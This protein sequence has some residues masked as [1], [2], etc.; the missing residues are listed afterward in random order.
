MMRDQKK[1]WFFGQRSTCHSY[2]QSVSTVLKA[3]ERGL[4]ISSWSC[5]STRCIYNAL[6]WIISE[7]IPYFSMAKTENLLS[8]PNLKKT[9]RHLSCFQTEH[10]Q[11]RPKFVQK[12]LQKPH[13]LTMLAACLGLPHLD[14]LS[15]DW[16]GHQEP[17]T[18]H[19]DKLTVEWDLLRD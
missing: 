15:Q 7:H 3:K 13:L 10:L 16:Q 17:H 2:L 1:K 8:E 9:P 12:L 14:L 6:W 19:E 4:R 5:F 11:S 18:A